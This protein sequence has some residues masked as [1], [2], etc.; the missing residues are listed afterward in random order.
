MAKS[1]K[2]GKQ[3][4]PQR[5]RLNAAGNTTLF[6]GKPTSLSNRI[7]SVGLDNMEERANRHL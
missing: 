6:L 1:K 5:K 2:T 3:G 4:R 7:P